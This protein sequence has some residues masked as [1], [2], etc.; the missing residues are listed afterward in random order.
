MNP[1]RTTFALLLLAL[2]AL[3][4]T[5]APAK[6][7]AKDQGDGTAAGKAAM[8]DEEG[9]GEGAKPAAKGKPRAAADGGDDA[10]SAKPADEASADSDDGAKADADGNTD[11]DADPDGKQAKG[12]L[13][14]PAAVDPSEPGTVEGVVLDKKKAPLAGVTVA[15]YGKRKGDKEA[16]NIDEAVVGADGSFTLAGPAGSYRV[17]V[18]DN[19]MKLGTKSVRIR[20]GGTSKVEMRLARKDPKSEGVRK[21]GEKNDNDYGGG[22]GGITDVNPGDRAMDKRAGNRRPG[23]T[24]QGPVENR[25]GGRSAGGRSGGGGPGR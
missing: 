7:A 16:S 4:A 14:K 13:K 11:A 9:D 5:L 8:A 17:I 18:T 19:D 6:P 3:P 10:E 21:A 20:A 2:F 22:A 15:L 25:A 24:G 12:A 23:S 1:T